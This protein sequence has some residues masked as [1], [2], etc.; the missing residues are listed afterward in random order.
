MATVITASKNP[1]FESITGLTNTTFDPDNYQEDRMATEAQIQQVMRAIG[2]LE[3]RKIHCC[4]EIV[5]WRSYVRVIAEGTGIVLSDWLENMQVGT[6]RRGEP[7]TVEF[8]L[9]HDST[10]FFD[11]RSGNR[12]YMYNFRIDVS[13]PGYA[14]KA[15][16]TFLTEAIT[17]PY[18]SAQNN[19][20]CEYTISDGDWL[21]GGNKV[22]T[23]G[24]LLNSNPGTPLPQFNIYNPGTRHTH[25]ADTYYIYKDSTTNKIKINVRRRD[26]YAADEYLALFFTQFVQRAAT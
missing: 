9:P 23:S 12:N 3:A 17:C 7:F 15:E 19:R 13:L 8:A 20:Y 26:Q 6:T 11:N 5:T 1:V 4:R 18:D 24:L 14:A 22:A 25:P 10:K 21:Y 2:D 16:N